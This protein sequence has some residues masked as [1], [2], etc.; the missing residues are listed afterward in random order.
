MCFVNKRLT[1]FSF[2]HIKHAHNKT[3]KVENKSKGKNNFL[4]YFF[5]QFVPVVKRQIN[6]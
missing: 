2:D 6:N 1:E 5:K 3:K 4:Q